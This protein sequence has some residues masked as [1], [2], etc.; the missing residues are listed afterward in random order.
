[1][2]G[3]R[4]E[5][6]YRVAGFGTRI[7]ILVLLE[8]GSLGLIEGEKVPIWWMWLWWLRQTREERGLEV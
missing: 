4:E 2:E 5:G 8:N 6:S 7:R 3:S 1:M